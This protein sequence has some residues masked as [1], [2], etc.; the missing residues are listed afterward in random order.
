[1]TEA[2]EVKVDVAP[3]VTVVVE[4]VIDKHEQADLGILLGFGWT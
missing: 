4:G 1:M 2:I 3:T